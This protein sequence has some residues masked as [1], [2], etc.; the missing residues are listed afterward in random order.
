MAHNTINISRQ[1]IPL[2]SA[3]RAAAS[4]GNS[5]FAVVTFYCA[6]ASGKRP[7]STGLTIKFDSRLKVL[8]AEEG[9][10]FSSK[11]F[12]TA[13]QLITNLNGRPV[14]QK[15]ISD[16]IWFA[17]TSN[18]EEIDEDGYLYFAR[19]QFP[20]D[21]A[22]GD[23]FSIS[24]ELEDAEENPYEFLYAVA[25]DTAAVNTQEMNWTKANGIINGGFTVI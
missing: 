18:S 5:Y 23:N 21:V 9:Q 17:A 8:G 4:N 2:V 11:V 25:S 6:S 3:Q 10:V 15:K 14:T 20:T 1:N 7:D 19:V 22:V 16:N 24:V 13:G 12:N